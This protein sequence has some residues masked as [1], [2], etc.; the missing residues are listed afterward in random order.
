ML[1]RIMSHSMMG[2]ILA[3]A[4][5]LGACNSSTSGQTAQQSATP[6]LRVRLSLDRAVFTKSEELCNPILT[7]DV[8]VGSHG[9]ARWNTLNGQRPPVTTS[10]EVLRQNY[11]IYAPVTFSRFIPLHDR[12]AAPTAEYITVGGQVGQDSYEADELP[13]LPEVG[14]HYIVVFAPPLS[15]TPLARGDAM[16]ASYAFPVTAAGVVILQQAGDPNEPGS[17]TPQPAITIPLADLT[18]LLVSCKP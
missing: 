14:G 3:L 18:Q 1:F 6:P 12:R 4:L 2:L 13:Q 17:G 9:A 7:A 5:I 10:A 16:L 8:M 15:A 11:F